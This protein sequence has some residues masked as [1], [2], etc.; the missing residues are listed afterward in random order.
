ML[1]SEASGL[2]LV[3]WLGLGLVFV[4]LGSGIRWLFRAP[5][6]DAEGLI[7]SFWL[8]FAFVLLGLQ[9]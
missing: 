9:V 6:V 5:A 7:L 1:P 4:G 2:V 3:A 8:G